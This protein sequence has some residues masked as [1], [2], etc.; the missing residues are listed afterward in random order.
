MRRTSVITIVMALTL[1]ACAGD[2]TEPVTRPT[3]A[4]SSTATTTTTTIPAPTTTLAP[5]D[6]VGTAAEPGLEELLRDLYEPDGVHNP[7]GPISAEAA[8]GAFD[9]ESKIAVVSADED[10][11]LAVA[12]PEWRIVGGWWPSLGLEP[13]LGSFPK[14]VAVIGSDARPGHDPLG[15]QADSI[16]FVGLTEDGTTSVLG[17]PRDA[18][19]PAP[20]L[21]NQKA[22]SILLRGGPEVLIEA[23]SDETGIEFDGMLLTGFE[24][25]TGLIAILGGLDIDVPLDL[26]DKWAKAYLDAGPQIL[27]PED[28]LAFVRVR[29]TIQ[30]GDFT[31]KK[32]G[33]MALIAAATMVQA[34]GIDAV[35]GILESAN[36]LYHTDLTA[37][38]ALLVAAALVRSDLANATNVVAPGFVDTTSGGA[39]I[40]RLADDAY[41]LFDDMADGRLDNPLED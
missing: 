4:V 27:S 35:P 16:H 1:T 31:R 24:G 17:L 34:M 6:I 40:V 8:I 23:L 11:T 2:A 32:H 10:V 19:I 21:G 9:E 25:F 15:S 3:Q 29:K 5:L 36:G 18:W 14:I 22:T 30:G 20:G 38:E 13:S 33:G 7:D 12:D 28:A 39:S 26:N 41:V 37:E